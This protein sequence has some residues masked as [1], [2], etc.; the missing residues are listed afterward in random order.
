[1]TA[2]PSGAPEAPVKRTFPAP[3]AVPTQEGPHGI[4]FDFNDGA[5][6]SLPEEGGPWRVRLSDLDTGNV[7]YE[8]EIKGGRVSTSK[9]YHLRVR[10]EI[11]RKTEAGLETILRHDY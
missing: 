4:R 7:L 9:R 6:V 8:T 2:Q 11:W 10:I 3:A 1:M 5:R